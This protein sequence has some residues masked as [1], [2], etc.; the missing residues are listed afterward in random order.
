MWRFPV[1]QCHLPPFIGW[2]NISHFSTNAQLYSIVNCI[3]CQGNCIF[4]MHHL[5]R[6]ATR[7]WVHELSFFSILTKTKYSQ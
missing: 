6:E 4:L 2:C 1:I 3:L 7:E 5:D